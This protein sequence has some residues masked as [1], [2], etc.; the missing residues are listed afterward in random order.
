M[1]TS[2]LIAMRFLAVVV[3]IPTI[4][5]PCHVS[6]QQFYITAKPGIYSSQ[7][8]DLDGFDTSF[9]GEL[10][11]GWQPIPN[12]AAEIGVGYLKG[13]TE[14][15]IAKSP[16]RPYSGELRV[17]DKNMGRFDRS[18]YLAYNLNA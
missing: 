17:Y 16:K 10:A 6:A 3:L 13:E 7:T 14:H 4:L 5:I 9:N 18:F 12:L 1:K 2:F 15:F 11:L 8:S